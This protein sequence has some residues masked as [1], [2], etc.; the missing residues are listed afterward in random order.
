MEL[1]AQ[2]LR[3]P[4]ASDL[5]PAQPLTCQR[6]ETWEGLAQ[7]GRTTKGEAGRDIDG[8]VPLLLN[9]QSAAI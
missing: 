5:L 6:G 2:P 9:F 4:G 3:L 7:Q 1:V 8:C